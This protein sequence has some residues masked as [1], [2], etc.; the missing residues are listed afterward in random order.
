VEEAKGKKGKDN[1]RD[2]RENQ[3]KAHLTKVL[4]TILYLLI[5]F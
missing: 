5:I 1:D 3:D 2:K 4:A